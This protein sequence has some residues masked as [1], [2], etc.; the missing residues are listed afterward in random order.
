MG[1]NFCRKITGVTLVELLIS[2]SIGLIITA[3]S[4]QLFLTG[5]QSYQLQQGLARIQEN[6]RTAYLILGRSIRS[7]GHFGCRA[8]NPQLPIHF[9]S[10]KNFLFL[11]KDRISIKGF[12]SDEFKH[13]SWLGTHLRRRIMRQSEILWINSAQEFFAL[14]QPTHEQAANL[15]VKTTNEFKAQQLMVLADCMQADILPIAAPPI[16]LP[17]AQVQQLPITVDLT[18]RHLSK[19]YRQAEVGLL[20]ATIFYVGKTF[21]HNASHQEVL[22]L[23]STDFNSRTWEFVEGVEYIKFL[24]A[25]PSHQ[26]LQFL[27]TKD[28]TDWQSV[29]GVRVFILLNSIEEVLS[30][31]QIYHREGEKILPN[32]RLLR[33]WFV[34]DF[35]IKNKTV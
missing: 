10:N 2:L 8:L 16:F 4:L 26:Q 12:S 20:S 28:V 30:K 34:F 22:A 9:H 35:P 23:Y 24:W 17:H 3:A 31:P 7:S 32:D 29:L 27:P 21:R 33:K 18:E 19:V 13:L 11:I 15:W 6:A 14:A 5:K 1:Y 25:V